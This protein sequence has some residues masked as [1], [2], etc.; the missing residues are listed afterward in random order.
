MAEHTDGMYTR[1]RKSTMAGQRLGQL[2]SCDA[3]G[4]AMR[5]ES[6]RQGDPGLEAWNPRILEECAIVGQ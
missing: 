2:V 5:C 1:T 3:T 4:C 6:L